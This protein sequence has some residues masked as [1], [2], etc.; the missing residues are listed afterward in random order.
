MKIGIFG[1][2]FNPPHK[3]HIAA[4]EG[5]IKAL[6][7][8]KLIIIPAGDPPHKELPEETPSAKE[9]MSLVKAAF[10][11][12]ECAE[13]TDIEM[14]R[15]GK[16]YTITTLEH[17]KKLYPEAT[18]YLLMGTDMF[19]TLDTWYRGS[20]ILEMISPAVFARKDAEADI[21]EQK[22]AECYE[23]YGTKSEIIDI[24]ITEAASTDIRTLLQNRQGRQMLSDAVYELIIKNRYY[25]AKPEYDWLRKCSYAYHKPKRIPHVMGCEEEAARLAERWGYDPDIAREA[26]ILHDITKRLGLEEQLILCDKYG[27]LNDAL[28]NKSEKL[29]HSKTGAEFS[30]DM[31]GIPDEVY[32]AIRW[33]T[34]GK[35]EMSLLE[36]IIYLA[37]YIEPNR[38]FDGLEALRKLCYEDI[39]AAMELGLKMSI[40]DLEQRGSPIH[41]KT[42]EAYNYYSK[43]KG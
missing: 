41:P 18:L 28:E 31:F 20:D 35:A 32:S 29:L 42:L 10:S 2:S 11:H 23:K 13:I 15:T 1:G 37:D 12:I 24:D 16:S 43:V 36:K 9:R 40:E 17:F 39:D 38:D 6:G 5:T 22:A 25:G 34:T 19:V 3:G 4:A 14:Q 21:L 33:H 8:D 7:L 26:G 27:I 30:R